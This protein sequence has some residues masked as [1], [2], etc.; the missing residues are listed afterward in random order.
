VER[1][2]SAPLDSIH[3]VTDPRELSPENVQVK[4]LLARR[5]G[6]V[7]FQFAAD[8]DKEMYNIKGSAQQSSISHKEE[9]DDGQVV[10]ALFDDTSTEKGSVEAKPSPSASSS[11]LP[12][13]SSPVGAGDP[14]LFVD[15]PE[16]VKN[17]F[18]LNVGNGK[19]VE[20]NLVS[21]SGLR[22]PT[23]P[24]GTKLRVR[25]CSVILV[26]GK[27][28]RS[29]AGTTRPPFIGCAFWQQVGPPRKV[30]YIKEAIDAGFYWADHVVEPS[31][32]ATQLAHADSE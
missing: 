29:V 9:D 27:A 32:V 23:N 20:A 24:N 3:I 28:I 19:L 8:C 10:D 16:V 5:D 6:L 22:S 30:H 4:E 11:S 31:L 21:N 1:R 17:V 26:N 25:G 7:T 14:M 2:L 18:K 12:L 13:G 15:P